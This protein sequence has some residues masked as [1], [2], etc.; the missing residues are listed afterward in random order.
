MGW[1]GNPQGLDKNGNPVGWY[2]TV[3]LAS[4]LGALHS[5]D[6]HFVPYAMQHATTGQIHPSCPRLKKAAFDRLEAVRWPVRFSAIIWD[7]DDLQA[8][9]ANKAA[10]AAGSSIKSS[11]SPEWRSGFIERYKQLPPGLIR[12]L[13]WYETR[14]G[15]RL[16]AVLPSPLSAD[17]YQDLYSRALTFLGEHGIQA[18]ERCSDP[19]RCFRLPRVLRDG[20]RQERPQGVQG[21]AFP[22]GSSIYGAMLARQPHRAT[23]GG[24]AGLDPYAGIDSIGGVAARIS[25]NRNSVLTSLAGRLRNMGLGEA[26][27]LST[28]ISTNEQR[29]DPPLDIAEVTRIAE[30]I[31]SYATKSELLGSD[32]NPRKALP[33]EPLLDADVRFSLGSDPELAREVCNQIETAG[34]PRCVFD[35][36]SLWGYVAK[37]GIW[38]P[39]GAHVLRDLVSSFDGEW[40]ATGKIRA[41]GKPECRR[42]K[43][44]G[45]TPEN[46]TRRIHDSRALPDWFSTDSGGV[47]FADSYVAASP[48]GI[49]RRAHDPKNRA[50]TA[51]PYPYTPGAVPMRFIAFLRDVWRGAADLETRISFIREFT[52]AALLGIATVFQRG[53]L[54]LGEGANGKS[55]LIKILSALFPA[56]AQTALAPQ[57]FGNEYR[58]AL[59]A[60]SR[61]NVVSEMPSTDILDSET[62]KSIIVGDS[63]DARHIRQDPFKFRPI[64]AHVF[65]ANRV[66]NVRDQ[67]HG[68]WRR[69]VMLRFERIY[70]DSEQDPYIADRIIGSEIAQIA[71]WT[72]EGAVNLLGRGRYRL[73]ESSDLALQEWRLSTDTVAR[74][75]SERLQPSE[76]GQIRAQGL[77]ANFQVWCHDQGNEPVSM[78]KFSDRLEKLGFSKG[79]DRTG[80]FWGAIFSVSGG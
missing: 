10:E 39:I 50:I 33:P 80:V 34:G 47:A 71:S 62:V 53:A 74:F 77:Y 25:E 21:L 42:I 16:A 18:D 56:S 69:W 44:S 54:L 19:T 48:S 79:R 35:R 17:Q 67:S 72:I 36:G 52:G 37:T 2:P 41:D 29:C 78:P 60:T 73:P 1:D 6:A 3:D 5:T 57:L 51:L 12:S 31:G 9:A 22:L 45:S 75:A 64:A 13:A 66:P 20:K 14:G 30:S 61:W 23:P 24:A 70:S 58:R 11:A 46:V 59:L 63:I 32:A 55:V 76:S 27:I 68:F 40:C 7:V 38:E 4:A 8:H 65:A 49:E 43:I 28:L 15:Y 26:E